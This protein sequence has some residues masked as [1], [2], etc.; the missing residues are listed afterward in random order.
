MD[1]SEPLLWILALRLGS[2][3]LF[4]YMYPRHY[5]YYFHLVFNLLRFLI[6]NIIRHGFGTSHNYNSNG[7]GLARLGGS[8][9]LIPFANITLASTI[10]RQSLKQT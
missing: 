1:V 7:A 10:C 3:T 9:L 2:S 6:I 8:A 5:T 4:R